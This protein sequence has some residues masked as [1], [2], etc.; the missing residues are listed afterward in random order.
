MALSELPSFPVYR[1]AAFLIGGGDGAMSVVAAVIDLAASG[2]AILGHSV[3]H[4]F[5]AADSVA[6][7]CGGGPCRYLPEGDIPIITRITRL[8]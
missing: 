3:A 4:A 5:G 8:C 2:Y 6:I 7:G 1:Q